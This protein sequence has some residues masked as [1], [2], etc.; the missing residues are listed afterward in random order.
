MP[1]NTVALDQLRNEARIFR[2]PRIIALNRLESRPRTLDFTRSLKAEVRDPL[3]M[4]TRQWQF[5]EFQGEDAGSP[6]TARISYRHHALDRVSLADQAAKG[7]AADKLPLEAYVEREPVPLILRESANGRIYS[8]VIYALRWGRAFLRRLDGAGLIGHAKVYTDA[9]PIRVL[10]PEPPPGFDREVSDHD[11]EQ[12]RLAVA[13]SVPDGV[14]IWHAVTTGAHDPW[15]DGEGPGDEGALKALALQFAQACSA[16]LERMFSAPGAGQSAWRPPNLEYG[17]ATAGPP[18]PGR[19]EDEAI[20]PVLVADQYPGGGLDWHSFDLADRP[21][22]LEGDP[23]PAPV[24]SELQSFLPGPVRFRGQPQPRFWQMEEAQTD[25][26]KIET[27]AT[28]LLHLMLAEFGLIFSNDWFM[29]PHVMKMNMLCEIEGILVDDCFGRHT[30]IRPAGQGKEANWQRFSLFHQSDRDG[31]SEANLFFLPPSVTK[32]LESAPIERVNFV[33]DEMANMAWAIET[34]VPSQMGT[35]MS[36]DQGSR[37]PPPAP[38]VAKTA[39]VLIRYEAGT[40]MPKNWIPFIPVHLDDSQS[41]I[42]LQ[43]ARMAGGRPPRGALLREPG[44]PYFV[45][46]EEVPRAGIFVDR[47]WQRARWIGGR[48]ITWLGRKKIAGRGE[49]SSG[50]AFDRIIDLKPPPEE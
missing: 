33:R 44:S 46:E 12:V 11:A 5:G 6:I 17:F 22:P 15:L 41:E 50:L 26:G 48:T 25:F 39:D 35:G 20:A 16:S 40:L 19:A 36:G 23:D 37:P 9:F 18:E 45:E 32:V 7:F 47:T 24:S 28:G 34:V 42:R 13:G 3:W 38:P 1:I 8:D 49:R 27:S 31:T 43:R 29:L 14:A 10:P 21:L 30:I 2:L 4:L